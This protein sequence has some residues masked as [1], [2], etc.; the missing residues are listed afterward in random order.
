MS[1][2]KHKTSAYFIVILGVLWLGI[3][4]VSHAANVTNARVWPAPDHT[5]LVFEIT[6][7]VEHTLFSMS[8][9]NRIVVD[10]SNVKLLTDLSD[11][12]L[13]GSPIKRIRSAVRNKRDLRV[14]LDVARQVEPKSF[15]LKPNEQYGNRLVID[16]YE[17]EKTQQAPKVVRSV[18]SQ[19]Q[20]RDIVVVIDAG[21]GGEDP[22]ALGPGRVREKD[23]VLAIS[24]ELKALVGSQRGMKAEMTRDGDYYVG[25]RQ[26]T[27]VARKHNADLLVSIHAD[28][29]NKPQASGASVYALSKRG[30]T[31]EA[32]RWLA[33]KENSADLIGGVGGVS[34]DDK[35]DVLAGVLLDLSMTASLNASLGVGNHVLKAMGGMTR[36]HKKRV[37]QA[38]FVVLKSPDIPS[39]LVETGFISNPVE[40]S[41]LKTRKY[42]K[43]MANAIYRG[44]DTHFKTT[45]PPGTLLS[46][47]QYSGQANSPKQ[48]KIQRGDTLSGIAKRNQ[49][50]VSQLRKENS[51]RSD[52]VKIGQVIR[53]PA[54]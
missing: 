23:V 54:S 42:Q 24:K 7:G 29:F 3:V 28:A 44:L 25:L 39:I 38:G 51:L 12:P 9:P 6:S 18:D 50:T 33:Q 2:R 47:Q 20:K 1:A 52:H 43:K 32:A 40:A 34:L 17:H 35:D 37:E 15:L 19:H 21:H 30:A 11:L 41:R 8:S 22:G 46:Y 49:V 14:V 48:Y 5:R 27:G 53:I 13:A 16:L 26:R 10:M 31:S 36:L 4:S 45:P